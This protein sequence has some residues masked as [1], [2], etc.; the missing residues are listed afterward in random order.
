M[1]TYKST[2][3]LLKG[4]TEIQYLWCAIRLHAIETLWKNEIL[5]FNCWICGFIHMTL[6][7]KNSYFF[8]LCIYTKQGVPIV[9]QYMYCFFMVALWYMEIPRIGVELELQMPAY[10]TVTATRDPSCIS[11]LY[12]SSQQCWIPDPLNKAMDW[13]CILMDTS[14][15]HFHWSTMG[16]PCFV[17]IHSLKYIYVYIYIYALIYIQVDM[18]IYIYMKVCIDMYMY[19]SAH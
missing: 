14:L 8:K 1:E 2:G 13:T 16:T 11:N 6:H 7:S 10:A 12:H 19:I 18:Y 17:Y 9:E 15:I 4:E 5:V 3:L